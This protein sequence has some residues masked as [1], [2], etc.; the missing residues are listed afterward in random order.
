[1][2]S[3]FNDDL[4]YI[5]HPAGQLKELNRRA[6]LGAIRE[7]LADLYTELED[8]DPDSCADAVAWVRSEI[9]RLHYDLI[10]GSFVVFVVKPL[11]EGDYESN[12]N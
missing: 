5:C 9:D 7:K 12:Q 11:K 8:L 3:K 2:N 6:N 4:F 10:H 1:M